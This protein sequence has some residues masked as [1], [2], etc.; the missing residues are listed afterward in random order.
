MSFL[1]KLFIC[2]VILFG[3]P[4]VM[5][6]DST[7]QRVPSASTS[8]SNPFVLMLPGLA[9]LSWWGWRKYAA[10]KE[11]RLWQSA[12]NHPI[13]L[14]PKPSPPTTIHL[15]EDQRIKGLAKRL[16]KTE[17][18]IRIAIKKAGPQVEDVKRELGL[19]SGLT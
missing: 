18:E 10:A 3:V 2:I 9:L 1:G 12:P 7:R 8:Q 16:G 5:L 19:N 14:A 13:I 15:N 17:L 6:G 4:I 11:S